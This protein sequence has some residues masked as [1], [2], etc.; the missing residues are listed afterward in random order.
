MPKVLLTQQIHPEGIELLKNN[1]LEVVIAQQTDEDYLSNVIKDYDAVIVRVTPMVERIIKAANKC[2]VIGRHGV[3]LDNIDVKTASACQIPVVYAPGSNS[4]AVA[5]HAVSMMLALAKNMWASNIKLRMHGDYGYRLKVK[6]TELS[7]KTLGLIGLGNIGRKVAMIC[8]KGF[9]MRLLGYDPY[10]KEE[11]LVNEGLSI[12]MLKDINALIADADII[13]LHLPGAQENGP[14]LGKKEILM[15]KKTAFL[16]NTA[17]GQ[18]IDEKALYNAL[19]DHVIAGA[20][21][22]VYDPEPPAVDNPLFELENVI[23]T[24]HMAAHTEEGTRN[25]AV[26]VAEN[27]ISVLQG[28]KPKALANPEIWEV[29]RRG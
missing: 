22:D 7:G 29:R 2:Q 13:S 12:T 11:F 15:M 21:L 4:N 5:E 6:C 10:I 23:A 8:Q 18:L 1:G 28:N 9:G 26:M 19:K 20:G 27:V 24:P 16:I 17:R 14:L 25:M 3:G